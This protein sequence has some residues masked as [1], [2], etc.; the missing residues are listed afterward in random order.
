[1][2]AAK[3]RISHEDMQR[4]QREF[5]KSGST[6]D[7]ECLIDY[8]RINKNWFN[9]L[10]A[11][12]GQGL[13]DYMVA[14]NDPMERYL[15]F[16]RPPPADLLILGVGT[17]RQVQSAN[18]LGYNAK[19]VT[20]GKRN[21]AF[22]K[23][24]FDLDLEYTDCCA[25]PYADSSFD[26]VIGTQLFE[27]I[28]S[29]YLFLFECNRVLKPGG[30]LVL[31]WPPMFDSRG[32]TSVDINDYEKLD[33]YMQHYGDTHHFNTWTP[34]QAQIMTK[35]AHFSNVEVY[36]AGVPA[37]LLDSAGQPPQGY[38]LI[39]EKSRYFYSHISPGMLIMYATKR[40]GNV[41]RYMR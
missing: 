2:V 5:Y 35:R 32:G 26:I 6:L 40:Q 33:E 15:L 30:L 4:E 9:L 34:A 13:D 12:D 24:K 21:V 19:G 38:S 18:M 14:D 29:P 39:T 41:P 10:S 8:K 28:H 1:M 16:R 7:K 23:W 25:T 31:E 17:G 37:E 20:L 27:H 3:Y 22:A 36:S 11:Q